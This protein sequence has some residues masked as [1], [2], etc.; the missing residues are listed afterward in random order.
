MS[1][2]YGLLF[3]TAHV[4]NLKRQVIRD[5]RP[6]TQGDENAVPTSMHLNWVTAHEE[7]SRSFEARFCLQRT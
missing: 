3:S 6:F 4:A 7:R 5:W 2:A 1:S